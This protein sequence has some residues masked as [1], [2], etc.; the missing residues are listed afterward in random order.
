MKYVV[1]VVCFQYGN[2]YVEADSPEEA[3]AKARD[4]Y[5][6][7]RIDWYDEKIGQMNV[8]KDYDFRKEEE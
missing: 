8:E 5:E 2:A 6:Q 4:L 3:K 7:R 1:E